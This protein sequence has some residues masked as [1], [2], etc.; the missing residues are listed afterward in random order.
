VRLT[1]DGLVFDPR[2]PAV[3]LGLQVTRQWQGAIYRIA[4]ENPAGAMRGVKTIE[5]KGRPG[6]IF[7]DTPAEH[8]TTDKPMGDQNQ[9]IFGLEHRQL[10]CPPFLEV[11]SRDHGNT[12]TFRQYLPHRPGEYIGVDVSAGQGVDRIVD[13]AGASVEVERVVPERFRTIFCLSVLEHCR[14]PF[15]MA[16]NLERLLSPGGYLYVSVPF[17]WRIHNY[18]ADYWRFT[19]DG[20]R[21][22]FPGMD[23][24]SEQ[25]VY[26]STAPG[27]FY[28]GS[29]PEPKIEFWFRSTRGSLL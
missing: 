22:L 1:W 13:L 27:R 6:V 11:G 20:V 10:L 8:R 12:A 15:Q 2:I 23:F 9:I 7:V 18:P 21:A 14:D 3:W 4:V 26:H 28:P 25:S 17:A 5:V 24:P 16:R 29:D 19:P